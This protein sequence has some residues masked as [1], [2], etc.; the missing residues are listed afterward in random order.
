MLYSKYPTL[1][2]LEDEKNALAIATT[3][4]I[5]ALDSIDKQI[6][7]DNMNIKLQKI[8]EKIDKLK[9]KIKTKKTGQ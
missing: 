8:D 1:R 6:E 2:A 4:K 3:K 9:N 7:Q 5:I